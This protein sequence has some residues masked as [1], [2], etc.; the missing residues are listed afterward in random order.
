MSRSDAD[1]GCGASRTSSGGFRSERTVTATPGSSPGFVCCSAG[2]EEVV[3]A[4]SG[5]LLRLGLLIARRI[6]G[7]VYCFGGGLYRYGSVLVKSLSVSWRFEKEGGEGEE[8]T[9]FREAFRF[10]ILIIF[11]FI[12][13][14]LATS[15]CRL[16]PLASQLLSSQIKCASAPELRAI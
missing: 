10:S 15:V 16:L 3:V 5:L 2:D 12:F 13:I 7:S 11:I 1:R 8:S 9:D 4:G 6:F 14:V